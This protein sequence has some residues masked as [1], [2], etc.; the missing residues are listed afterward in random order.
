[1]QKRI[2]AMVQQNKEKDQ[3][4]LLE[5]IT[6]PISSTVHDALVACAELRVLLAKFGQNHLG[7]HEDDAVSRDFFAIQSAQMEVM[8]MLKAVSNRET[9]EYSAQRELVELSKRKLELEHDL[10]SVSSRVDQQDRLSHAVLVRVDE[11]ERKLIRKSSSQS[12][13][14]DSEKPS[15]IRTLSMAD[16]GALMSEGE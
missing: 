1:V 7:D 12:R 8:A 2:K 5:D 16:M 9:E 4:K 10:G 11:A 13:I 6:A 3:Q 14:I 15:L